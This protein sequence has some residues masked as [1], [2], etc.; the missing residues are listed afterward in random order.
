ML[1]WPQLSLGGGAECCRLQS[2]A[3]RRRIEISGCD[4]DRRLGL[5][6]SLTDTTLSRVPAVAKP[7]GDPVPWQHVA[8]L[9]VLTTI[10]V[11]SYGYSLEIPDSTRDIYTAYRISVGQIFPLEGPVF[12]GAMHGGP[13]WFYLLAIP[14]ILYKSWLAVALFV[15]IV[16]GLK[17]ILAYVCGS[18]LVDRRFGLVWALVLALPGWSTLEQVAFTH[19]NLAEACVLATLYFAIRVRE[20]PDLGRVLVLGIA[21]GL[22]FHAHP[23][24]APVVPLSLGV[25]LL[26]RPQ[27]RRTTVVFIFFAG[28]LAP[29]TPYLVSQVRNGFPDF[30]TSAGYVTANVQ[31]SQVANVPTIVRSVLFDGPLLIVRDLIGV[32]PPRVRF[33][34]AGVIVFL[35]AAL[36]G[37]IRSVR[38]AGG[39]RML[40]LTSGGVA[41]FAVV[42][43]CLRTEP[44]VY[45]VHALI[46]SIAALV[47]IGIHTFT[48]NRLGSRILFAFA[49]IVIA[50]QS[51][52]SLTVAAEMDQ[53]VGTLP[54]V[55]YI[56]AGLSAEPST[57]V[58]FPSLAHDDRGKFLCRYGDRVAVHGPM[59]F[60]VDMNVGVDALIHCNR[61]PDIQLIG[62]G[63]SNRTHWVSMPRDFW[64]QASLSPRCWVGSLGLATEMSVIAPVGSVARVSGETFLPRRFLQGPSSERTL[65]F[66][67]RAGQALL[68]T[69]VIQWYMPWQVL[70]VK[71][72][73]R[74]IPPLA[75]TAV[76]RLYGIPAA[77]GVETHR[78]NVRFSAPDADKIDVVTIG[79]PARAVDDAPSCVDAG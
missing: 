56:S 9:L 26:A 33:V 8:V 61:I 29:F 67:M 49:S 36:I 13:V 41:L 5:Y 46:P 66:D 39:A 43:A 28:F 32:P 18:H 45:F 4:R 30:Q 10:Y 15:G 17:F 25:A 63:D 47:A 57:N 64:T 62:V 11:A 78:W 55:G 6:G 59:A 51:L 24:T 1:R 75:V 2:D 60:L 72:D 3:S 76:S 44:P 65:G 42:I 20:R 53:G 37:A 14:L 73:G 34:E 27:L 21:C 19:V 22:A 38:A 52:V 16:A 50:G 7:E 71:V 58:W 74:E 69:N 31:L 23:T 77:P 79:P 12:G 48:S 70:S 35:V 68:F 40:W 54:G